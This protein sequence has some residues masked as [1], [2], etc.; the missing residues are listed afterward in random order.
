MSPSGRS[1][2]RERDRNDHDRSNRHKSRN[3]D[4][5][6]S[7]A[8]S[9][10]AISAAANDVA[11]DRQQRK[12]RDKHH[13]IL[14]AI[15]DI[16]K[17]EANTTEKLR[18]LEDVI[19]RQR[20]DPSTLCDVLDDIAGKPIAQATPL[21]IACFEGDPDVI[22][23][24]IEAGADPNQTESEHHLTPIHVLCDAEYHG[25]F[26][27]QKERADLVRMLIKRGAKVNHLDR[28]AMTALHKSVIHDRPECVQAL[29]E[30]K[31]DPNVIYLG[32]TPLS[33]AARHNRLRICQILL[34]YHDTNVN[35]RNDQGGTSLHFA[36]AAI[37]DSPECVELL[38]SNGARVNVVDV[39]RNSP[40]MVA[41]FFGKSNILSTLI[42]AGADLT[43][44]NNEARTALDIAK[45]R[46]HEK[47]I[48]I[49]TKYSNQNSSSHRSDEKLADDMNR[50][51]IRK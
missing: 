42:R 4:D 7:S 15:W 1:S 10:A 5:D 31:A 30:A 35:H 33:I 2:G 27:R 26:I 18:K 37:A 43:L 48:A 47:C 38:L 19:V 40:A 32:D 6:S 17:D 49:L 41:T 36:C 24:L 28:N 22:R 12:F 14:R 20:N 3:I 13:P 46:E 21:I 25:Q 23:F 29:M 50:M 16:D 8:N 44:Q 51:K 34:K 11:R 9:A 39:R 45:E